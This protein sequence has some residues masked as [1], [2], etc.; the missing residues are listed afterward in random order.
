VVLIHGTDDTVVPIEKNS[1]EMLRRYEK[2]GKRNL[3]RVIEIERQGHNF[4]PEY[5]QSEDLVDTA[6][7][8]AKLGAR[9]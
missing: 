9:Q 8:N 5:F 2:A 3:I 7:A 6:I 1:N 4:W